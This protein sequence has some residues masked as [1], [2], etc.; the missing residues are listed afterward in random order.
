MRVQEVMTTE[1]ACCTPDVDLQQIARKMVE[2]NCGAIP[3]VDNYGSKHL[4]GI[5]TDR[6]IVCRTIAL[7]KDP[8]DLS[9]RDCM[10]T[11]VATVKPYDTLE[12]C[13]Q[14]MEQYDVRRIPVVDG[15]GCCCGIVS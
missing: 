5:V 6:D 7:G 14:V 3:I 10:T 2:Q 9:A 4:L 13:C 15:D 11:T 1:P 8:M 12:T